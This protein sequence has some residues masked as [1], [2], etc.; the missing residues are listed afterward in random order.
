MQF[1]DKGKKKWCVYL[2]Y[3]MLCQREL[4]GMRSSA[5]LAIGQQSM[6]AFLGFSKKLVSGK[7]MVAEESCRHQCFGWKAQGKKESLPWAYEGHSK[8]LY[9]KGSSTK[10]RA[11]EGTALYH[12]HYVCSISLSL[13][14]LIL[15]K[16]H[17]LPLSLA[18]LLI[19]MLISPVCTQMLRRGLCCYTSSSYAESA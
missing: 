5:P 7:T 8:D 18:L 15:Q 10:Y 19:L 2:L 11:A 14:V 12:C 3:G 6:N 17:L 16:A 9:S 13:C 4:D 1:S